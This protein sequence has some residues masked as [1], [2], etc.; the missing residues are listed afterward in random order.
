MLVIAA[1]LAAAAAHASMYRTEDPSRLLHKIYIP[2]TI[3]EQAKVIMPDGTEREVGRVLA[4]PTSS[5]HPGFTASK[6]GIGGQIIA[7]AANTHHIQI[8]VEEGAGRTMSIVPM[9]TYVAA[10]GENSSFVIEGEGGLGIWGEYAPYVGSPVY[11]I[12][13]AGQ[14]V[15][16]NTPQVY[17]F[18]KAIE[19]RVYEPDDTIEYFQVENKLRGRAWYH[20][21]TGDHDFGVVEQTVSSTGRFEGTVYEGVGMVRANHPGVVCISTSERGRVGGFQ[22]VP[23]SHTFSHELQRTRK[24]SQYIVLRGPEFEDLTGQPPFYRGHVRPG[25]E[26]AQNRMAGR[27]ICMING[28]WQDVPEVS[29]LTE[30]SLE[31]I[32]AFRIYVREPMLGPKTAEAAAADEELTASR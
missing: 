11:I 18:A 23:R 22:I 24:M 2:M 10:S 27:V 25:D 14:P 3:G 21:A 13:Q 4:F 20:D 19:I 30:H 12:N 6:Y 28:E 32:E 1:I 9:R 15:L 8:D 29:G 26:T 17:K 31:H 7:S 5:R 16:F